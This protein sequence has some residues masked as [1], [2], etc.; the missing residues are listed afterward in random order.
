MLGAQSNTTALLHDRETLR[1]KASAH[2]E[3]QQVELLQFFNLKHQPVLSSTSNTSLYLL[4]QAMLPEAAQLQHGT[5]LYDSL[6]EQS[7]ARS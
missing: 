1:F 4:Q 3:A 2:H 5:R 6:S 7:A